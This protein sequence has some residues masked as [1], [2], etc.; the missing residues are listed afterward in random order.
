ML[1]TIYLSVNCYPS[2]IGPGQDAA[3]Y[4]TEEDDNKRAND[5]KKFTLPEVAARTPFRV[6]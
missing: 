5:G 6:S 2:W 1:T 4:N 3:C